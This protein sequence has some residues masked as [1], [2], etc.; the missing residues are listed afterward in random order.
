MDYLISKSANNS[1]RI[2]ENNSKSR[3]ELNEL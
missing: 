2:S 3:D 1:L